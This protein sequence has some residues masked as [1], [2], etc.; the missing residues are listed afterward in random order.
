MTE[1]KLKKELEVALPAL[2][3]LLTL[4]NYR[5]AE[6]LLLMC[7]MNVVNTIELL[8]YMGRDIDYGYEP[9]TSETPLADLLSWVDYMKAY[10]NTDKKIEVEIILGKREYKRFIQLSMEFLNLPLT[11][12]EGAK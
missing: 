11:A 6:S 10:D 5:T 8:M 3:M 2:Q 4:N 9:K 7:H 12:Q 1:K